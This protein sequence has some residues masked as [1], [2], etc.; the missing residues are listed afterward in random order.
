MTGETMAETKIEPALTPEEWQVIRI[1]GDISIPNAAVVEPIASA[2]EAGIIGMDSYGYAIPIP[3]S[4]SIAVA[5]D[6]LR[7]SDPRK[8]TREMVKAL[9]RLADEVSD[10]SGPARRDRCDDV[11]SVADVLESYLP[12][13]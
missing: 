11:R 9:R 2:D 7:D 1:R 6:A 3:L 8:I 4:V 12:P 13:E 5:N 10:F